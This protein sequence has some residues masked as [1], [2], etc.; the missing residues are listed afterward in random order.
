MAI[1]A[2]DDEIPCVQ[3]EQGHVV[4]QQPRLHAVDRSTQHLCIMVGSF[5]KMRVQ[6][7]CD[8]T[9]VQQHAV[10]LQRCAKRA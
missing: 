4:V 9:I 6:A 10:A 8:A 3:I 5:E 2:G 7:A 1:A